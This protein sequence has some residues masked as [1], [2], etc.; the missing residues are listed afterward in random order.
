MFKKDKMIYLKK[1]KIK[2]F[3]VF[4]QEQ[5]L[6]FSIPV[7][8]NS[9]LTVILGPNNS[10]KS[11]V[12][13]AII[14]LYRSKI[15]P[16]SERHG[17]EDVEITLID[18]ENKEKIIKNVDGGSTLEYLGE[19][20]ID[21]L[22]IVYISSRKPWDHNFEA[23]PMEYNSFNV[24]IL[25]TDMKKNYQPQKE[26]GKLLTY[27][28]QKNNEKLKFNNLMSK[29]ISD[30][31]IWT[32]D[33]LIEGGQDYVKYTTPK[34]EN[35][36]TKFLGDG[37]IGLFYTIA[38]LTGADDNK[39]ILIDEPELSLHPQIQKKLAKFLYESS[40]TKQIII[41]THSPYFINLEEVSNG[42]TM[43]RLNNC[44]DRGCIVSHITKDK[45][46]LSKIITLPNYQRPHLLD[47]VAKELF[48]AE[49][50]VFLEGQ[51]DVGLLME[52]IKKENINTNF[53]FFGYGSG[54]ASNIEYFLGLAN[55]IGLKSGALF[56]GDKKDLKKQ[57]EEKF[58]NSLIQILPTNDIRDKF[59]KDAKCNDTEE[60]DKEGIFNSKG[61]IKANYKNDLIKIIQN[62]VNHFE[63]NDIQEQRI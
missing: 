42:A 37:V 52:F 59:K 12:L 36:S 27:I 15:I 2:N 34:G 33:T 43:I 38:R 10:G 35:H 20:N 53:E 8:G 50:V 30:F 14:K 23:Q 44:A 7:N 21:P 48:F 58:K 56:D 46:Y 54:G 17:K 31:N 11:T 13:N 49:N 62:F 51:E 61:E 18:N 32:I 40:K 25:N 39:I 9:G 4:Y 26:F 28:H 60:I 5:T 55:D 47:A 6:E 57:C 16:E 24:Q 45:T 3:K 22:S 19:S 63:K 1:L 41:S 29:F